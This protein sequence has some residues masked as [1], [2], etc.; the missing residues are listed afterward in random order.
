MSG[1]YLLLISSRLHGLNGKPS[2]LLRHQTRYVHKAKWPI[3]CIAWTQIQSALLDLR[4]S[5]VWLQANKPKC[6]KLLEDK[7]VHH[8]LILTLKTPCWLHSCEE[9]NQ[10]KNSGFSTGGLVKSGCLW[11]RVQNPLKATLL[12]NMHCVLSAQRLLS[13]SYFLKSSALSMRSISKTSGNTQWF[14]LLPL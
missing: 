9:R 5:C 7:A 10:R 14:Y 3:H 1:V 11:A 6:L 13:P 8:M 12:S 2:L 4:A